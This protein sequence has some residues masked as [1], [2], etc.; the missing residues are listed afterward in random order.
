VHCLFRRMFRPHSQ[1]STSPERLSESSAGHLMSSM[2]CLRA[3]GA[4]S[5]RFVEALSELHKKP[6][7]LLLAKMTTGNLSRPP[8]GA[9]V[10]RPAGR[11]GELK[12]SSNDLVGLPFAD[13]CYRI[14]HNC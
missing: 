9:I 14:G 13:R 8:L 4:A 1:C 6:A 10:N 12:Q 2:T 11:C 5:F 7:P 3:C